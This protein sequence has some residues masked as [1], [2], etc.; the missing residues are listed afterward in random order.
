L[1]EIG[2]SG[3]IEAAGGLLWRSSGPLRLVAIVHRPKYDDWTLPK[4][5]REKGESMEEAARREVQ[6]ETGCTAG[7]NEFAG[8]TCYLVDG[9]PKVVLYWHMELEI[10]RPF[11]ANEEISELLWLP[12]E[13]AE[14][15]LTYASE[16]TLLMESDDVD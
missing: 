3:I 11:R 6:E 1:K 13:A 9:V 12:V 4:G 16:R 7:L 2:K 14:Q 15:R 10:E 5:W 8:C